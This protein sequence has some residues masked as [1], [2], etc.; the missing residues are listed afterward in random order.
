VL[1]S[2]AVSSVLF[3]AVASCSGGGKPPPPAETTALDSG[4][5]GAN[6]AT[7]PSGTEDA[8]M[9]APVDAEQTMDASMGVSTD[10]APDVTQVMQATCVATDPDASDVLPMM[11]LGKCVNIDTDSKNCGGCSQPCNLP[12]EICDFGMC[13][14]P[15]P[16][17]VCSGQCVDITQ[18]PTN[19]GSCGHNCQGNPCST[20]NCQASAI[21][22]LISPPLF[23]SS[24]AVDD[25]S[26]YWTQGANTPGAGIYV[27]PFAGSNATAAGLGPSDDPRGIAVGHN[28][29]YWVDYLDGTVNQRPLLG[30]APVALV[31]PPGDAGSNGPV[32]ITLDANNNV[33]WV[34]SIDG[35]V[36]QLSISEDGSTPTA[37]V[38]IPGQDTPV[39]VAVDATNIYWINYGS[40]GNPGSVNKAPLVAPHTITHLAP[41]EDSPWGLA[42]DS[43]H[44]YWTNRVN[45]TGTV[46]SVPIAGG[47]IVTIAQNQGAPYG[48]AVDSQYVYWTNY[49]NNTVN[50]APLAGGSLYMLA[51]GQSNVE[52]SNPSALAV[53]AMSVYWANYGS[54]YIMKVAK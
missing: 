33:Y 18:D 22:P 46:K 49:D 39:A 44:V 21:A 9:T 10:A 38:L 16:Q 42:I 36:N 30:G 25:T 8:S 17:I 19:C 24:I 47:T 31:S 26:L 13:R 5:G 11:C 45:S 48:I 20:S 54:G 51:S 34:G 7:M 43:T 40:Q 12:G 1:T 23:L 3:V 37:N 15:D 35:T 4:G 50:K 32:A 27:K 28:D 52:V 2:V 6:D 53:D 41:S 29:L 14:C